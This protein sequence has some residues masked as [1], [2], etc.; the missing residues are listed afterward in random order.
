MWSFFMCL[1]AGLGKPGN[2]TMLTQLQITT[3]KPTTLSD[4][5]GLALVVQPS[6]EALALPLP[7]WWR[8][9]DAAYRALANH[10]PC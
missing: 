1:L 5:Q 10:L 3:A 6:G 9:Q 2:T 8:C 4:G 7:I